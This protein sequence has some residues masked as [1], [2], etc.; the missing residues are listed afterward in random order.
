MMGSVD[1]KRT[2]WKQVADFRIKQIGSLI[3]AVHTDSL[4]VQDRPLNPLD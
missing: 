4:I 1:N 3:T 2:Y